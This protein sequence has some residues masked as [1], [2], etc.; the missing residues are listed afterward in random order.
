[1]T[2]IGNNFDYKKA[3]ENAKHFYVREMDKHFVES[4]FIITKELQN[5]HEKYKSLANDILREVMP[6]KR[7]IPMIS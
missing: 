3:L 6:E 1:M 4:K 7:V 2:S 5:L